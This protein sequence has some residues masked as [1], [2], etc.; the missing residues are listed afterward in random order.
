[1]HALAALLVVTA[2]AAPPERA[3]TAVEACQQLGRATSASSLIGDVVPLP[4]DVDPRNAVAVAA[5]AVV[6]F[7]QRDGR[8]TAFDGAGRVR[9]SYGRSGDGPGEIARPF[10]TR[11][12]GV[13]GAQWVAAD[14][15]RVLVF[16]GRTF[17]RFNQDGELA[18]SWSA[19]GL[20]GD[21][22]RWSRRVR[23]S[24]EQAY[25]DLQ[26]MVPRAHE[27]TDSSAGRW[28]EVFASDSSSTRLVAALELPAL[29]TA[30]GG[31]VAD[32]LAQA[33]PLWDLQGDCLVLTDGHSSRF[34]LADVT[35]AQ[36]DTVDIG[37]PEWYVDVGLVNKE[38]QGLV[39]GGRPMPEPT[40][41]AR[42]ADLTLAADGTLWLRP[43]AQSARGTAGQVVWRYN[44]RT[45]VLSQDTVVAFPRYADETGAVYAITSDADGRT[46]LERIV[47]TKRP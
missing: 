39:Q 35:S 2:C 18:T 28:F 37:L 26:R 31:G 8:V 38:T 4:D 30:L 25:L 11:I 13:T 43:A 15:E 47:P 19:A 6:A 21:G 3:R 20:A 36:R 12:I 27:T 7:D 34:V 1:M 16:D 45:G 14:G 46:R 42:I 23:V 22:V 24:G 41:R 33:K 29:P 9:W 10:S 17:F 32:G 40:A 44:L 5:S